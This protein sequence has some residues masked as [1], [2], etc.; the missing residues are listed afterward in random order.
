MLSTI[1]NARGAMFHSLQAIMN[2]L[3]KVT[4]TFV[5]FRKKNPIVN[6]LKVHIGKKEEKKLR[7]YF[8]Y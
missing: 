2:I 8:N 5:H 6:F 7:P 4:P 1:I 3:D